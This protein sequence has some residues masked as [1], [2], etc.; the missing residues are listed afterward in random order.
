MTFA[1]KNKDSFRGQQSIFTDYIHCAQ[2]TST[3]T[4]SAANRRKSNQ[5]AIKV[6][7]PPAAKVSKSPMQK[8]AANEGR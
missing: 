3:N 4:T 8:S 2:P 6:V 5:P 7:L 1:K